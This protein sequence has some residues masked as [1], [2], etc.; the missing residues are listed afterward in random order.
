MAD[1]KDFLSQTNAST[2][3]SVI[4]A[5][6]AAPTGTYATYKNSTISFRDGLSKILP[7]KFRLRAVDDF[8]RAAD[9]ILEKSATLADEYEMCRLDHGQ[10]PNKN[11]TDHF[12]TQRKQPKQQQQNVLLRMDPLLLNHL[13]VSIRLRQEQ[14]R[15]HGHNCA[16]H[17]YILS[18][19][20]YCRDVLSFSKHVVHRLTESQT[21]HTMVV[22]STTKGCEHVSM[23][24][25]S[26]ARPQDAW[27]LGDVTN[28]PHRNRAPTNKNEV[29][30]ETTNEEFSSPS[31]PKMPSRP[32]SP[33]GETLGR[34]GTGSDD[35]VNADDRFQCIAFLSTMDRLVGVV[36]DRFDT[37]K[38][39]C[40]L[41]KGFQ[42]NGDDDDPRLLHHL[43][44]ASIATNLCMECVQSTWAQ[45]SLEHPHVRTMYDLIALVFVFPEIDQN[46]YP[47][48][49]E[50]SSTRY[51]HLILH[52]VADIIE[53]CFSM[54]EGL[55]AS[56]AGQPDRCRAPGRGPHRRGR[57]R[58]GCLG[59]GHRGHAG[60][61]CH[62]LEQQLG[63]H[64]MRTWIVWSNTC[65]VAA[66][67]I[68]DVTSTCPL[69]MCPQTTS[70]GTD[71][72]LVARSYD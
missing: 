23:T 19:L 20:N 70:A 26:I 34:H 59:G 55:D 42:N 29:T 51:P 16:G 25:R 7:K 2:S 22:T 17:G 58:C 13:D 3:A 71:G 11:A 4:P 31:R 60:P 12:P 9:W 15:K 21:M 49:F 39:V 35:L 48:L 43:M 10:N 62:S 56:K 24:W 44:E 65:L 36:R 61:A 54:E 64:W 66:K 72:A 57:H 40:M 69:H 8:K 67:W 1:V 46:K 53:S 28:S 45:L 68:A 33:S 41:N 14:A 32:H 63:R 37:V 52:F 27:E 50:H 38:E 47:D 30:V 6:G 5:S 18:V